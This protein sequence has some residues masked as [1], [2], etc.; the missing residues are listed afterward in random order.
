[1]SH[2]VR[3]GNKKQP[4]SVCMATVNRSYVLNMVDKV[5]IIEKNNFRNYDR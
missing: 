3:P 1:M 4:Y 5:A 2:T